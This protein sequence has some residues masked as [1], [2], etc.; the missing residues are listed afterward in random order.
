[1]LSNFIL[2]LR[3]HL[4]IPRIVCDHA[5]DATS[6]IFIQGQAELRC[7]GDSFTGPN[8]K[9]NGTLKVKRCLISPEKYQLSKEYIS[10]LLSSKIPDAFMNRARKRF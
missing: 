4:C 9:R 3:K 1:M 2:Q 7:D 10:V 6:I 5:T 8:S